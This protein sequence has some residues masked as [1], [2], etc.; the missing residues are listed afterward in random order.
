MARESIIYDLWQKGQPT[1]LEVGNAPIMEA[2][3]PP[4]LL[5]KVGK[6]FHVGNVIPIF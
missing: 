2:L 6:Q 5:R 4:P 3:A 1:L